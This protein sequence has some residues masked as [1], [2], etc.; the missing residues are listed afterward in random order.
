MTLGICP[1]RAA[2]L[3]RSYFLTGTIGQEYLSRDQSLAA[4]LGCI[5]HHVIIMSIVMV[6]RS[7]QDEDHHHS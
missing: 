2:Q 7:H 4:V 1:Q 3:Q 5:N 6:K